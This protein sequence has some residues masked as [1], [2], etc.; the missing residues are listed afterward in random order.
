MNAALQC[1]VKQFINYFFHYYFFIVIYIGDSRG[2]IVPP[3]TQ[4]VMLPGMSLG[5]ILGRVKGI[6]MEGGIDTLVVLGIFATCQSG[7]SLGVKGLLGQ[8]KGGWS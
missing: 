3:P 8:R 1:Q 2:R 6:F 7:F 4:F 5:G